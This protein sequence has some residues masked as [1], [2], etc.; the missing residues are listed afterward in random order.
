LPNLI[1]DT[2]RPSNNNILIEIAF[3]KNIIF[4][5]ITARIEIENPSPNVEVEPVENFPVKTGGGEE[6]EGKEESQE[7]EQG[8]LEDEPSVVVPM[9]EKSQ[10][11][12]KMN[13]EL[14]IKSLAQDYDYDESEEDPPIESEESES[15]ESSQSE[16]ESSSSTSSESESESSTSSESESDLENNKDHNH[17]H[18][19]HGKLIYYKLKSKKTR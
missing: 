7:E 8:Y 2:F 10:S 3:N 4:L 17:K 18:H 1:F 13:K 15:S 16:S 11:F 5:H 6:E 19:H 12:A 9:T 14:F